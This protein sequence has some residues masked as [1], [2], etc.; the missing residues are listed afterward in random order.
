[1]KVILSIIVILAI[2]IGAVGFFRG[3]FTLTSQSEESGRSA[4]L[5]IDTGK[6]ESDKDRIMD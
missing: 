4:T 3:W 2:V 1:M 5:K 6:I